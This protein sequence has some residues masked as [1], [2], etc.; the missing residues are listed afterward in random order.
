MFQN[1]GSSLNPRLSVGEASS[2]RSRC[3]VWRDRTSARQRVEELLDMVRLPP[4]Y[5]LRYPHQ[6]SGGER[7]RVAI[8][9]ALAT[10]PR[11][12][13]C[14]EPVSALDVSV[15]A[16]IVN[17]LADL[18]DQFGLAYLFISH[19]LAVV[20]Q[21]SDRVAVMY[22]GPYLRDGDAGRTAGVTAPS[23]YA[24]AAR[25]GDRRCA[26]RRETIRRYGR[27]RNIRLCLCR[28]LPTLPATGVRNVCAVTANCRGLAPSGV[29]P[30]SS[31]RAAAQCRAA[32]IDC[33]LI[34]KDPPACLPH[35]GSRQSDPVAVETR[36]RLARGG[37][38]DGGKAR[39]GGAAAGI[40]ARRGRRRRAGLEIEIR[41]RMRILPDDA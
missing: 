36:G 32:A 29:P 28:A 4:S 12:I 27:A 26:R 21:L 30:R 8:A 41:R 20:A 14:D 31:I 1:V 13:V 9:R 19:D 37:S 40:E 11:F 10:E 5:R 18:R 24:H 3:S 15:Q 39:A 34:A 2:G 25:R 35:C 7:Q 16:A 23:L 17:L 22:H 33:R 38:L 6:L